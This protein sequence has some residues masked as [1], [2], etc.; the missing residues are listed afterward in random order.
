M[1][2][3]FAKR[4]AIAVAVGL[5]MLVQAANAGTINVD[6]NR[7][8]IT[9]VGTA[10]APDT[11]TFWNGTNG[12]AAGFTL[13]NM[14][15]ST[16]VVGVADLTVGA[17]FSNFNADVGT[18][19]PVVPLDLMRDYIYKRNTET[20]N[21]ITT[22][23][24]FNELA[25]G[26]YKLYIYAAGDTPGQGG[27]F[28]LA[29]ANQFVGGVS[30]GSTTAAHRDIYNGGL[31]VNYTVLDAVTTAGSIA[32]NWSRLAGQNF[33]GLNGIQIQQVPEPATFA[34]AALGI[35]CVLLRRRK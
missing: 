2:H 4:S 19:P 21:P 20:I 22:T 31:G 14:T 15:D 12:G 30:A 17:Y 6:F 24:T 18:N 1:L 8:G 29:A 25:D 33:G 3:A 9:Y 7:A 34:L 35:G 5:A 11:G 27:N 13:S 16:S 23:L 32:I 26:T 28:S 10:I